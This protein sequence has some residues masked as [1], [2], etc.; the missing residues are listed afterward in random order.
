MQ[1]SLRVR[2]VCFG[3]LRPCGLRTD[4]LLPH[5]HYEYRHQV[6]YFRSAVASLNFPNVLHFLQ[7]C[8]ATSIA[9][10]SHQN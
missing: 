6:Q 9:V 7:V 10:V 2:A 8:A 5:P 1:P 3:T 4:V